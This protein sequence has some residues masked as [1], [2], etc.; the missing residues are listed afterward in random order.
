M[1]DFWD[2]ILD[3]FASQG[4]KVA[5]VM[6]FDREVTKINKDILNDYASEILNNKRIYR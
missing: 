4:N 2:I 1:R 3:S 5:Q 6:K